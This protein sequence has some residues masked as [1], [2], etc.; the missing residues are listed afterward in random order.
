L[1]KALQRTEAPTPTALPFDAEAPTTWLL[2]P[3]PGAAGLLVRW[4]VDVNRYGCYHV[5]LVGHDGN[6]VATK[7]MQ[8]QAAVPAFYGDV[9]VKGAD[10]NDLY[11]SYGFDDPDVVDLDGTVVNKP[12]VVVLRPRR[13]D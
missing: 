9:V 12:R 8:R 7:Q 1:L 13:K 10:R 4:V 5:T 11:A 3:E 6:G 2:L